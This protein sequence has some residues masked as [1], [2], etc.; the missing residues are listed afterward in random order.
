MAIRK[1]LDTASRTRSEGQGA[2]FVRDIQET[3]MWFLKNIVSTHPIVRIR[4]DRRHTTKRPPKPTG[5]SMSYESIPMDNAPHALDQD[6]D[7]EVFSPRPDVAS[8]EL[9][10]SR[11]E[12]TSQESDDSD[13]EDFG[14]PTPLI[15][16][17]SDLTSPTPYN[18]TLIHVSCSDDPD[19][20]TSLSLVIA[21]SGVMFTSF[22]EGPEE[23]DAA[24]SDGPGTLLPTRTGLA[25]ASIQHPP[26]TPK[27]CTAATPAIVFTMPTPQISQSPIF[28]PRSPITLAKYVQA[29]SPRT[30]LASPVSNG[31]LYP[32]PSIP[33][34]DRCCLAQLEEGYI[35]RSCERQWLAC[36]MW[37]QVND[38]GRRRWLTE[39]LIRPAESTASIRAVM[40]VFGVPGD[41]SK[42]GL[43]LELKV[44]KD[45]P[46]KV[47][48]TPL[49]PSSLRR[50]QMRKSTKPR[51]WN[52]V[53]AMFSSSL[54]T[55]L[56][57]SRAPHPIPLGGLSKKSSGTSYDSRAT[58]LDARIAP[59]RRQ[60][61]CSPPTPCYGSSLAGL[62]CITSN[63]RFVE[64]L[65]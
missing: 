8:K 62:A 7:A 31:S 23:N 61:H 17:D 14:Q 48:A 25:E 22:C 15:R 39:P 4:S 58:S 29:T 47:V 54:K 45:L 33:S 44:K 36:K 49:D 27:S 46:F 55:L 56:H 35:C 34:C 32:V 13:C 11:I 12:K 24:T 53:R 30:F 1:V 65:V 52:G 42:V 37:Y 2:R 20:S 10:S 5:S 50:R 43:G 26:R 57:A 16:R 21:D 59:H 41:A 6:N 60:P 38:G 28:Q 40:G 3:S 64:H 19:P 9:R 18:T 63:S 51:A